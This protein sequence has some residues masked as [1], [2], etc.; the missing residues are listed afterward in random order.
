MC[1]LLTIKDTKEKKSRIIILKI[2]NASY[3]LLDI[4]VDWKF[5]NKA[6]KLVV[7]VINKEVYF[8]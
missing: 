1:V 4:I 5:F 3:V 6:L 2:S 7:I 8:C